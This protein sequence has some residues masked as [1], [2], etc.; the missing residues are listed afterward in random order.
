MK[1]RINILMIVALA[2]FSVQGLGQSSCEN[3]DFS[4]GDFTNWTGYTSV[5]PQN[6]AGANI[7]NT[8]AYY[9]TEGIVP[10]RHTIITN[11][12]P[13]PFTCGNVMTIAPGETSS[14]RLGNGGIGAW[15]NGVRWQ[16]DYLEY[17]VSVSEFNALLIYKYAV[18]LQDPNSG[19]GI[20]S[21]A[22]PIKPRFKVSIKDE[23]DQL[24]DP[25]C[26]IYSV[27]AD[28]SVDGFRNCS[29]ADAQAS[30]GQFNSNGGVIYRAW[31]TV[32]V[33][34]RQYVGQDVTLLFET[35]D[36]G[37]GGHFGYAYLSAKC[38]SMGI[39]AESC[40]P[41]DGVTLTAPDGF[42]YVWSTG[43]TTQTIDIPNA[44]AGDTVRVVLTTTTGC[45]T[46]LYTVLNPAKIRAV[47]KADP[48]AICQ[49][50][51]ISFTDSSWSKFLLD[52]AEIPIVKRT[53]KFG[54]GTI[55]DS[56][57]ESPSHTY[58]NYGEYEVTLIVENDFGCTDSLKRTITVHPFPVT[59]F[60]FEPNCVNK[61]T[62]FE[63]ASL[64]I[65]GSISDWTWK[66]G[67][68]VTSNEIDPKHVYTTAGTFDVELFTVSDFG[69]KDSVEK[70]VESWFPPTA[71]FT[72][73]QACTGDSLFLF[74]NSAAQVD[75]TIKNYLWNFGDGTSLSILESPSHVYHSAGAFTVSLNITSDRGCVHDTTMDVQV[76]QGPTIDFEIENVCLNTPVEF[77]NNSLPIDSIAT[78][79][80]DF[81]D[82][83]VNTSDETP[84]HTY[85]NSSFYTVKLIGENTNGCID[86]IKKTLQVAPNPIVNFK[87]KDVCLSE[88]TSFKDQ[89]IISSGFS[90][91]WEWSFGDDSVSIDQNPDHLYLNEDVY[92]VKLVVE[93]DLGCIDSVTKTVEVKPSP[94]PVFQVDSICLGE[95]IQFNNQ[96]ISGGVG[97]MTYL[98][99]FGDG[100]PLKEQA[101]PSYIYKIDSTFTA[102]LTVS[103]NGC[104]SDTVMPVVV[105]PV[106]NAEIEFEGVCL[107]SPTSLLDASESKS[108]IVEWDWYFKED[109]SHQSTQDAEFSTASAFGFDAQLIVTAEN[110]CKD[111]TEAA[112]AVTPN[113]IVDFLTQSKCEGEEMRFTSL[114]TVSKGFVEEWIW[115]FGDG[116]TST[117]KDPI[118]A[119]DTSGVLN[120]QLIVSTSDDCV[121]SVL[122][123]IEVWGQPIVNFSTPI[124]CLGTVSEF[125]DSTIVGGNAVINSWVWNTGDGSLLKSSK[126]INHLYSSV[127][128][129]NVTLSVVTTNG[130]ADTLSKI[131]K[132][133]QLPE[134]D[135][136]NETV[137]FGEVT[138]F[139]NLSADVLAIK[140]WTW[141]FDNGTSSK[142]ENPENLFA[143]TGDFDVSLVGID[144]N[145]C[146][147]SELKSIVVKPLPS[148]IFD[149]D[150]YTG[151]VP[152]CMLFFD[153]SIAPLDTISKWEW[154]FGDGGESLEQLP[155]YCYEAPGTYNVSLSLTTINGCE[156]SLSWD[157]MIT[158]YPMPVAGFSFGPQPTTELN[159]KITFSDES[160]GADQWTWDF[161]DGN[162]SVDTNPVNDYYSYGDYE[163]TQIVKTRYG[164][165]DSISDWVRIEPEYKLY[166]ANA[167]TPNGDDIN[168]VFFPVGIGVDPDP[169]RYTFMVFD[170]WGNKIFETHDINE[171]WDGKVNTFE[172][173]NTGKI[174]QVDVYVWRAI[175]Y[176][177]TS[178]KERHEKIGHVSLIK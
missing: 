80:W 155:E 112:L 171:G 55:D 125:I 62:E 58:T 118:H 46:D 109:N 18:V 88:L 4:M 159:S 158:I 15:G 106:P 17:T 37:L 144:T 41:N 134:I 110:G 25:V 102:K 11:S 86:S 121:D 145:G 127:N 174:Q 142:L 53:W 72:G 115:D 93:S 78:W 148:P 167:F 169:D 34:L 152:Q 123:P 82:G 29:Q 43:Q 67:D 74:N 104:T 13:D 100:S 6:T 111:T 168:D 40:A 163:V 119:F 98:W 132:V 150:H 96:S 63:S 105:L 151:C 157:S 128:D 141:D 64:I 66:F 49:N 101:S 172:F 9:Y 175:V 71:N 165:V 61:A 135:F 113:P 12:T 131:A 23:N 3:S 147:G 133:N 83:V 139:S 95:S 77:K 54:D 154:T 59:D 32:G 164:C 2:V 70:Q 39:D 38:D 60:T 52:S 178:S 126:N 68:G 177:I 176:D 97:L 103:Q 22:A 143:T 137:C 1:N 51:E 120:V 10:G 14:V 170:R 33:D 94:I 99:D 8:V 31:T 28:E 107:G 36:C 91:K 136:S 130:C 161:G 129:F 89:T 47:F 153:Y 44:V 69:C 116:T 5:Y 160:L 57:S 75:D 149:A 50:E 65:S 81:G 122:I 35:W 19:A 48:T 45:S 21:H 87:T 173:L 27:T 146:S 162:L 84:I 156:N 108:T 7:G 24:I 42:S 56:N 138:S 16:R 166:A 30:G 140:D 92:N 90:S 85:T 20:A 73:G 117:D 114:A 76:L 124:V 79:Y 26:G